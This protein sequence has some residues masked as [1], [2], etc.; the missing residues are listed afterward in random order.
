MSAAFRELP[1]PLLT[2]E[3]TCTFITVPRKRPIVVMLWNPQRFTGN[4][5]GIQFRVA[6]PAASAVAFAVGLHTVARRMREG[7][8]L[9]EGQD[10]GRI[11]LELP[12]NATLFVFLT[13]DDCDHIANVLQEAVTYARQKALVVPR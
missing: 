4:T 13:A 5:P 8:G 12:G 11:P 6:L 10:Y 3:A 7:E 9:V 2:A 1:I